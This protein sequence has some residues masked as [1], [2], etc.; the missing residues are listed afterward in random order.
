MLQYQVMP[1]CTNYINYNR[2]VQED[3]NAAFIELDAFLKEEK[4]KLDEIPIKTYYT[5]SKSIDTFRTLKNKLTRVYN[6]QVSTN[7]SMKMWE[8]LSTFN[9][10]YKDKFKIF[11]N[12]ELPGSFITTINH[13]IRTRTKFNYNWLASS[14]FSTNGTLG[15]YYGL[16]EHNPTH[17]IMDKT[18][19]GDI[20][21][22]HNIIKIAYRVKSKFLDGVDLYT[23]DI[24]VDVSNGYNDQEEKMLLLNY[25]QILCGILCL[26]RG[27]NM[28]TKQ[29]TFFTPFSRSLIQLLTVLFEEVHITK[30]E[31][32]R[33]INS[34]IYIVCLRYKGISVTLQKKLMKI[35]KTDIVKNTIV[36]NINDNIN[37]LLYYIADNIYNRQIIAL[38]FA[39][40]LYKKHNNEVDHLVE[41]FKNA[42]DKIQNEWVF[43]N[44]MSKIQNWHKLPMASTLKNI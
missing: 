19:N 25:M 42:N 18:M 15:D 44:Y 17:W 3:K 11:C 36:M 8:L 20:S 35:A 34:E 27:G 21:K 9:L 38:R 10:I 33:P 24:G 32:S 26:A 37:S 41:L 28:V 14:Y 23:S 13:F 2:I 6:M 29:F 12:A 5:I 22:L 39:Y 4:S 30:P 1:Y 43:K 31:T 16:Y 40:K 7:A